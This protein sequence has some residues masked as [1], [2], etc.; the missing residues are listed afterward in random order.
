MYRTP[1]QCRLLTTVRMPDDGSDIPENRHVIRQ[2]FRCEAVDS[3][4][5]CPVLILKA[6]YDRKHRL[7]IEQEAEEA[8]IRAEEAGEQ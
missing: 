2:A 4:E 3:P 8:R 5:K 6:E 1:F 7:Q